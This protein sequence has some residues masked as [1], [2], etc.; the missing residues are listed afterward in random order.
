MNG[1]TVYA[2][3]AAV[4]GEAIVIA[5]NIIF[6]GDLPQ[7]ILIL[8]IVVS[9][10]IYVSSAWVYFI[11]LDRSDDK[12]GT[13]VG[14]LGVN[15]WGFNLYS[16][17]AL[18]ALLAMNL[19]VIVD[20]FSDTYPVD[21]KYQLLV[22]GILLIFLVTTRFFSKTVEGQVKNVYE[23]EE[24]LK[25]GLEDMKSATRRLQDAIFVCEDVSPEIR[26]MMDSIQTDIR[27]LSPVKSREAKD[28][29]ADFVAKVNALIPAFINY[30]MN[31]ES[32]SKQIVLL[33]HIVDNRKKI[34]N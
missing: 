29:E 4:L 2:I 1:K 13:W 30:K 15:L 9:T 17:F 14:T 3:I 12:V 11:K 18:I 21:I 8:N 25:S 24:A 27:Y 10:L 20:Q 19:H 23:K 34:Y 32:I 5:L 31:A 16:L 26:K 22:H 28:I 7:N 33:S 6:R